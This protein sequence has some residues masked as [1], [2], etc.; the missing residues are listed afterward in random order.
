[1]QKE[2]QEF[3]PPVSDDEQQVADEDLS[4]IQQPEVERPF[5]EPLEELSS[6]L[7]RRRKQREK[8]R[9]RRRKRRTRGRGRPLDST[10]S[11]SQIGTIAVDDADDDSAVVDDGDI[12]GDEEDEKNE[13]AAPDDVDRR[14]HHHTTLLT[15]SSQ[16]QIFLSP[17]D[18]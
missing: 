18:E 9:S 2:F 1:M 6:N 15:Q 5:S 10:Q 8:S 12:A 17:D 14:N 4:H 3:T 16:I 7:D 11:L 13:Q